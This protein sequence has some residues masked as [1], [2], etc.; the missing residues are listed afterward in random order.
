MEATQKTERTLIVLKPETLELHY[1]GRILNYFDQKSFKSIAMVQKRA[2]AEKMREHYADVIARVG[3][4]IGEDIVARMTRGD[5]IFIV[6]EGI[7]VV[8]TSRQMVGATDP[9]NAGHDTIRYQFGISLQYNAIH[10]SD[11]VESAE[12]EIKIWFPELFP[13]V[14]NV[15]FTDNSNNSTDNSN[16]VPFYTGC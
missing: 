5:C 6:Y 14:I 16:M 8:G 4:T 13:R 11:S 12:R 9:K 15:E 7:D 1:T 10:A 3:P 2:S